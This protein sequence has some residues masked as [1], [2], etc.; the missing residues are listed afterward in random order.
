MGML[1]RFRDGNA[2]PKCGKASRAGVLGRCPATRS[3]FF[4]NAR[5]DLSERRFSEALGC[6]ITVGQY[7]ERH[8][9]VLSQGHQS[10]KLRPTELAHTEVASF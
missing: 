5:D 7:L 9:A 10:A 6:V 2:S 8:D 4:M 3:S 1:Y